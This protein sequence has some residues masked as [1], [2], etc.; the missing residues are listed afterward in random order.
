MKQKKL[1]LLFCIFGLLITT[2]CKNRKLSINIKTN[3]EKIL[4][5][6]ELQTLEYVYNSYVIIT[7]EKTQ[8]KLDEI[9]AEKEIV[10]FFEQKDLSYKEHKELFYQAKSILD[11]YNDAASL[12]NNNDDY[13]YV[14]NIFCDYYDEKITDFNFD[15]IKHEIDEI[16]LFF[17]TNEEYATNFV[18]KYGEDVYNSI[19]DKVGTAYNFL[20]NV[21]SNYIEK[22]EVETNDKKLPETVQ[23][24]IDAPKETLFQV[25]DDKLYYQMVDRVHNVYTDEYIMNL[26]INDLQYAVK[27]N[28]VVKLGI[29]EPITFT[30]NEQDK[31]IHIIL[32][33]V[34][35]LD[36]SI[37]NTGDKRPT[38]L[39]RKDK[40][41]TDTTVTKEAQSLCKKD[42]AMQV[43]NDKKYISLARE[44]L[45]E[46]V[47]ALCS[48]FENNTQYK[49][50]IED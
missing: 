10:K 26:K 23:K 22:E 31:E 24:M 21:Y 2:S 34:K 44:N 7:S 48:P 47:L 40:Y 8:E 19:F 13:T 17:K 33:N 6:N 4:E 20:N 3:L 38:Y 45:K 11:K 41:R 37:K 43:Q 42:L 12:I 39:Y 16:Y 15:Y 46:T 9:E 36:V 27:Y 14:N 25:N 32:P 35:I 1:I 28:G 50:I 5:I 18:N 30:V 29:D 49:F